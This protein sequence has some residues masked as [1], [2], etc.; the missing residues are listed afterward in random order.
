MSSMA[1][2]YFSIFFPEEAWT[3]QQQQQ[4]IKVFSFT[5]MALP[6]LLKK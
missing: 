5:Y 6:I 2:K 3:Q 1:D 4:F